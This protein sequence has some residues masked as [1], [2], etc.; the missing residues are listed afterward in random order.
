MF[1][2]FQFMSEGG[3]DSPESAALYGFPPEDCR[4]V[5]IRSA[6][7]AAYVLMDT[8]ASGRPYLYGVNCVR[9]GTRW[10]DRASGNG[11]GWSQTD[12]DPDLGTLS[13][14]HEAPIGA[15]MARVEFQGNVIDEPVKDGAFLVV[16][17][18][19]P[20]PH[21]WPRVTA[22]KIDGRWIN[23][24][25]VVEIPDE[26]EYGDL[27]LAAQDGDVMRVREL[28]AEGRSPNAFDEIS[29]TPFHYA[30]ESGHIDIMQVL[31][32]AGADVNAIDKPRIGNT[33]LRDVACECSLAVA[34]F[35]VDA[36]AD[37]RIPG[38]MQLTALHKAEERTDD[39]GQRVYTLLKNVADR[40]G[41]S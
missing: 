3:F 35:L 19:V 17:W 32:D 38:W 25:P 37:P 29:K 28:L 18:R 30:A 20:P 14:W 27:H 26:R 8:H 24:E 31:L 12:D 5:A 10:F 36:G 13:L 11:P 33:P 21:D 9:E 2:V 16:W 4:V 41:T 34:Q 22:F 39:E 40:L 23:H 15:D 1:L 7:D 6:G